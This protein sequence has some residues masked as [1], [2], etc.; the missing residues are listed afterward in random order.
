MGWTIDDDVVPAGKCIILGVPHTSM[1]D[2]VVSYLY[3]KGVGGD[4]RCMVKKELFFPPVGWILRALGAFPIDRGSSTKVMM[5]TI[6]EMERAET[7]HL[8][9]APEGTRKPV[10][11]WKTGF[12]LGD[13]ACR[14][15]QG[16]Q[17]D[18]RS[19]RRHEGYPGDIRTDA[20]H[21]KTSR[22]I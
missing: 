11:A 2:F 13:Q 3:Y 17:T 8:A 9:I 7:F 20:S 15:R 21:S 1:W 4:A 16:V 22:K 5:S 12:H 19:S 10:R 14:T 18:G 6:H